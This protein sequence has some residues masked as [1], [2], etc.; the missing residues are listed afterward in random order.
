MRLPALA[1]AALAVSVADLPHAAAAS[2]V[3]HTR[4]A[5]S[6]VRVIGNVAEV[7]VHCYHLREARC[8]GTVTLR[9]RLRKGGKA[10]VVGRREFS[11]RHGLIAAVRVP[12]SAPARRAIRA[13]RGRL[14]VTAQAHTRNPGT[15]VRRHRRVALFARAAAIERPTLV[16]VH[17]GGPA[18]ITG[19]C[20]G[21]ADGYYS[22]AYRSSGASTG[23]FPGTFTEEGTYKETSRRSGFGVLKTTFTI[24]S[25]T[26][27]ITGTR[28]L[29]V[30]ANCP[31]QENEGDG[32]IGGYDT[33]TAT[34]EF[35]T[36]TGPDGQRTTYRDAGLSDITVFHN[37]DGT[38]RST[39]GFMP[40]GPLD[41]S[42]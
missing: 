36:G 18:T 21:D 30:F 3:S 31:R 4:I 1:V 38:F 13:G 22:F 34:I 23:T 37:A 2:P 17:L 27:T 11:L 19:D 33:Y 40:G 15:D 14:V 25:G 20:R 9:A 16:F 41:W 10:T 28:S 26:T 12:L 39:S 29:K 24:M 8:A 35:A 42:S 5:H 7:P 32:V 6:A